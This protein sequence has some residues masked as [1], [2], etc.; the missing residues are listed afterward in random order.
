MAFTQLSTFHDFCSSITSLPTLRALYRPGSSSQESSWYKEAT[1]T[2]RS[3]HQ[4]CSGR[5]LNSLPSVY[6][7]VLLIFLRSS[8]SNSP[9]V[10]TVSALL[11]SSAPHSPL[12]SCCAHCL[13]PPF[14]PSRATHKSLKNDNSYHFLSHFQGSVLSILHSH[15]FCA[16]GTIISPILQ[17]RRPRQGEA[18]FTQL[19]SGRGRCPWCP[20]QL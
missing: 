12:I 9:P 18:K 5:H 11:S 7:H 8:S 13:H 10:L 17:T 15:D 14:Q 16:G 4:C 2:F 19:V 1:E 20:V 3:E 6:P